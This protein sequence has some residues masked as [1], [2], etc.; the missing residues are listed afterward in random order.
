LVRLS[1]PNRGFDVQKTAKDCKN[2]YCM[3]VRVLRDTSAELS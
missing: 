2:M 3:G 1:W